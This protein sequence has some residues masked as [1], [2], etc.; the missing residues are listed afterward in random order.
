MQ[1]LLLIRQWLEKIEHDIG[2]HSAKEFNKIVYETRK[3]VDIELWD[4]II[5][6]ERSP[7]VR[8]SS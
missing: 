8:K 3:K 1:T 6:K 2:M 4:R 7:Y 5:S